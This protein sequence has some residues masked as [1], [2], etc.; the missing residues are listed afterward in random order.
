MRR[1]TVMSALKYAHRAA[2]RAEEPQVPQRFVNSDSLH[3]EFA[4]PAS[5]AFIKHM[6]N[7]S[8]GSNSSLSIFACAPFDERQML[9]RDRMA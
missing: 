6:R 2:R 4:G 1:M 8:V 7:Y 5:R 3:D 9:K